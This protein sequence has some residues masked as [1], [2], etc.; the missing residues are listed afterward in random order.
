MFATDKIIVYRSRTEEAM[1]RW[2]WEGD[3]LLFIGILV[4]VT[5]VVS[6]LVYLTRKRD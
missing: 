5:A 1:D 4:A 6:L 3:G 2:M